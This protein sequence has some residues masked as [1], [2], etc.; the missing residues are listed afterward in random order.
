M[1]NLLQFGLLVRVSSVVPLLFLSDH[2]LNLGPLIVYFFQ[3]SLD[4]FEV[5]IAHLGLIC[6][7]VNLHSIRLECCL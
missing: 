6:E 1:L 4:V 2:G 3:V 5:F 7:L